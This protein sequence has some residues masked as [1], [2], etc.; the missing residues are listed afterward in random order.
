MTPDWAELDDDLGRLGR[1]AGVGLS[2]RLQ[3]TVS[4]LSPPFPAYSTRR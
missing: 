4:D 2:S 3:E 1:W